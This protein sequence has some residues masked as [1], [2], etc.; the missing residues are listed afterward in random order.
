MSIRRRVEKLERK[1]CFA[2]GRCPD[3]PPLAF[4]DAYADG[5]LPGRAYPPRCASCG[6][7]HGVPAFIE[8]RVPGE[9]GRLI[10]QFWAA[11][12]AGDRDGMGRALEALTAPDPAEL[13]RLRR[14]PARELVRL[15]EAEVLQCPR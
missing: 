13:D 10:R 5:P 11:R 8:V 12:E 4:V 7:P 2:P 1:A 3:C 14:L 9:E 15:Y 6:G